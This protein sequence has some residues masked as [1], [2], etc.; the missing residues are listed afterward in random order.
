MA[1][2]KILIWDDMQHE[3]EKMKNLLVP[4]IAAHKWDMNVEIR[5]ERYTE[6]QSFLQKNHHDYQLLILDC[7]NEGRGNVAIQ[8]L[9]MLNKIGSDLKVIVTSVYQPEGF[10]LL[11]DEYGRHK[12]RAILKNP[13]QSTNHAERMELII[14]EFLDLNADYSGT[15]SKVKLNIETEGKFNLKYLVELIGGEETI[16]LLILRLKE[17]LGYN[18]DTSQFTLKELSQ[19]LSGAIVFNLAIKDSKN[20]STFR[21][22]KLSKDKNS[23][24]IELSKARNEYLEIPPNYTL[25]YIS[26]EP[27]GFKDY[28]VVLAVLVDRSISLRTKIFTDSK[29]DL[30][31]KII[32]EL[33]TKC[34]TELYHKR[35]LENTK[36][37]TAHSI[38]KVFDTRRIA[39]LNASNE[40]LEKLTG[41]ID[42]VQKIEE[43]QKEITVDSI[44]YQKDNLKNILVHGDLHSNNVIITENDRIFIIDPA[45]MG[46]DHWSRD[47]CML[48]VDIFA[49]GIDTGTRN[50]FG[51]AKINNWTKMGTKII[52]NTE[53]ENGGINKGIVA[54]INWLIKK[55]NLSRIFK[56]FFELWEFQMSLGVEFLRASYKNDTLPAGK[57]AACL[58]IGIEAINIARKTYEKSFGLK[59]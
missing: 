44:F 39:F 45:N 36:E 31:I 22:V 1:K 9:R 8:A 53:I 27:I 19:G 20:N 10:E 42:I 21:F 14:A 7:V 16:K 50:Y 2:F 33:W 46:K 56:D 59:S 51:I 28:Y 55:E 38:L 32:D 35:R 30:S 17:Q 29:G 54:S 24:D 57:R 25:S 11:P 26:T 37:Q 48:I 4:T 15:T 34:F 5:N 49:Y 13:F 52:N 6:F 58:L 23:M 12:C 47:I 3:A 40:E 18:I 41:K 43:L